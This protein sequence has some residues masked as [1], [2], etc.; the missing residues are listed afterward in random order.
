MK[1]I[2]PTSAGFW[3]RAI[4]VLTAR[5]TIFPPTAPGIWQRAIASVLFAV[6][7]ALMLVWLNHVNWFQI[8]WLLVGLFLALASVFFAAVWRHGFG[9]LFSR[10]ALR[11]RAAWVATLLTLVVLFYTEESWRG[12]R[13]WAGVAARGL[14][15]R[16]VNGNHPAGASRDSRRSE[17]RQSPRYG[18][19]ARN[20]KSTQ[21]RLAKFRLAVL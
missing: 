11:F 6:P 1:D 7:S 19:V 8:V 13:A 2:P 3:Q 14:R 4:R 21:F 10:R 20:H 18:R 12:K 15:P 16:R 9:W 5:I 17:L